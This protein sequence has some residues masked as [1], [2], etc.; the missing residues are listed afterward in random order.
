[1]IGK[2]FLTAGSAGILG[3]SGQTGLA[4]NSL[5][6]KKMIAK[7]TEEY[8]KL[9]FLSNGN[10][11]LTFSYQPH[12]SDTKRVIKIQDD[13]SQGV[14]NSMHKEFELMKKANKIDSAFARPVA[15]HKNIPDNL[16]NALMEEDG[17]KAGF[18]RTRKTKDKMNFYDVS[19]LLSNQAENLSKNDEAYTMLREGVRNG[20]V[21]P[22]IEMTKADG[23]VRGLYLQYAFRCVKN[24]DPRMAVNPVMHSEAVN[25]AEWQPYKDEKFSE[26]ERGPG[27]KYDGDTQV[28]PLGSHF[29]FAKSCKTGDETRCVLQK[30]IP[31]SIDHETA[32]EAFNE[33][34]GFQSACTNSLVPAVTKLNKAGICHKDIY[35]KNVLYKRD[36]YKQD[37]Y[38]FEISDFG[39]A[40]E[41]RKN[42]YG[43]FHDYMTNF[44]VMKDVG[45][46][47]PKELLA[48][49]PR[50]LFDKRLGFEGG[51]NGV[52]SRIRLIVPKIPLGVENAL[53]N[54]AKVSRAHVEGWIGVDPKNW[55]E[56]K[57]LLAQWSH[58][59]HVE[60]Q[61]LDQWPHGPWSVELEKFRDPNKV[62]RSEQLEKFRDPRS[63]ILNN[64]I[65]LTK[66]LTNAY[67]AVFTELN[68][69]FPHKSPFSD[70]IADSIFPIKNV[71][72]P[73]TIIN[74]G[75]L[76]DALGHIMS[77]KISPHGDCPDAGMVTEMCKYPTWAKNMNESNFQGVLMKGLDEKSLFFNEK[78]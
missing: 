60:K 63:E 68:S 33:E 42:P 50:T 25:G 62:P 29:Q 13:D 15:Y 73:Q 46:L 74:T 66:D 75:Y 69:I 1:M 61:L 30:R 31:L 72:L 24:A 40:A 38:N 18:F 27:M 10:F 14:G 6:L 34:Y 45:I 65:V 48:M 2:G 35:L 12:G 51:D 77:W 71:L 47:S 43:T 49:D 9:K 39:I 76:T 28:C 44:L 5:V 3:L 64:K 23:D 16:R 41:P 21:M 59:S 56:F 4:V 32:W 7:K 55:T 53:V 67:N 57:K 37:V 19:Y 58:G 8:D 54:L 78:V 20:K 22:A 17:A 52:R 36:P 26:K 11:G 70:E